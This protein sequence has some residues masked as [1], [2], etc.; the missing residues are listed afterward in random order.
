M[1][2][3]SFTNS[4]ISISVIYPSITNPFMLPSI[5]HKSNHPSIHSYK[6]FYPAFDSSMHPFILHKSIHPSLQ[7]SFPTPS[8]HLLQIHPSFRNLSLPPSIIL[9]KSFYPTIYQS[10]LF[11]S[12]HPSCTHLSILYKDTNPS[13]QLLQNYL[14][15]HL[16]Q[17]Q[18]SILLYICYKPIHPSILQHYCAC[19]ENQPHGYSKVSVFIYQVDNHTLTVW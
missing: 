12:I 10:I 7:P 2:H 17:L 19:T 6:S 3:P 15:I 11:N 4:F 1:I 16:L 18:P 5:F 13:I 14:S 8:I 9:Y